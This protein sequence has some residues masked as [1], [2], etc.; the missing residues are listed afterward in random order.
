MT[1]LYNFA[2]KIETSW[3]KK[4]VKPI[5]ETSNANNVIVNVWFIR[6]LLKK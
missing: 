5:L 6:S 1:T 3:T 2:F 4:V